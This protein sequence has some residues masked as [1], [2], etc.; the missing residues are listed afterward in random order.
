M[1][2]PIALITGGTGFLGRHLGRAF[3]DECAVVL[4]GRNH[5]QN[6]AAQEFSGCPVLPL[7]VTNIEAVRDVFAEV[8]PEVVVHAAA[9][10]YVDTAERQ[11][12]ECIDANVLGS[13]NVARVA[14]E[15]GVRAVIGISTDKAAPPVAN[16][17]GLTKALME[18]LFCGMNGKT[19]TRF[20]CV[21]FGNMPWSTGS[22]FPA[23]KR[24]QELNDG[25]IGSTGP[26]MTRLFSPVDEAVRLV[27]TAIR[28]IDSLQGTVLSRQM[29]AALIR[30]I[31]ELWVKHRGGSWKPIEGRPGERQHEH[32]IGE[33]ELLYTAETEF[34]G[35]PHYVISFNRP[36]AKP[37]PA[38]ISSEN[39]ERFTD[40]EILKIILNPP[41]DAS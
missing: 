36:A 5:D 39:A 40:E 32:L 27:Q 21:R 13:Q 29:K 28:N 11:P 2:K 18:R 34:D 16:T 8:K 30:D 25:V 17:Y 26:H 9:S 33:P 22:V 7:D 14:V 10:K 35:I 15:K 4:T 31:L 3:R 12:N 20:A 41:P 6:R 38:A 23:W 19:A 37:L 1:A 24:M